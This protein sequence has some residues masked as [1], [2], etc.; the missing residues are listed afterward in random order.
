MWRCRGACGGGG[1]AV[2]IAMEGSFIA[3]ASVCFAAVSCA[4]CAAVLSATASLTTLLTKL[5]TDSS[6][7]LTEPAPDVGGPSRFHDSSSLMVIFGRDA[8]SLAAWH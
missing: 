6:C 8:M 5:S 4:A 1:A 3:L 7:C 2:G